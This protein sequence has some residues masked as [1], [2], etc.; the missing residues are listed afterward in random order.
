MIEALQ[1]SAEL[2]ERVLSAILTRSPFQ[3]L[4]ERYQGISFTA[5]ESYCL[6]VADH[7]ERHEERRS[8]GVYQGDKPYPLHFACRCL[9]CEELRFISDARDLRVFIYTH[10][11]HEVQAER[12]KF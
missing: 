4:R 7:A 2:T 9:T 10:K 12:S 6:A 5:S 8:L 3:D 1:S 11:G